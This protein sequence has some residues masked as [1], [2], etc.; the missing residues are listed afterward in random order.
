V[1]ELAL[2]LANRLVA[3]FLGPTALIETDR[4]TLEKT[5][6]A[7][8]VV[9]FTSNWGASTSTIDGS[10][11]AMVAVVDAGDI[12]ANLIIRASLII[13][14]WLIAAKLFDRRRL[15]VCNFALEF[16]LPHVRKHVAKAIV[17]ARCGAGLAVARRSINIARAQ[18]QDLV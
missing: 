5:R 2:G 10:I 12:R 7:N 14:V 17:L 8:I 11:H 4:I 1:L 9:S 16:K 3:R 18:P 15:G 13:A 6:D